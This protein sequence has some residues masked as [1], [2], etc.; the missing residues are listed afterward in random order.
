MI[1]SENASRENKLSICFV[2]ETYLPEVNGVARTLSNVITSLANASHTVSL[3]RPRQK[4]DAELNRDQYPCVTHLVMPIPLPWYKGI[5]GGMPAFWKL[6]SVWKSTRPDVIYIATEGPLGFAALIVATLLKI[7]VISGFHTNFPSYCQHYRV[8]F[9]EPLIYRYLRFFHNKTA[10]TL[11]P[12]R[13]VKAD[14][15]ARGF[16]RTEIFGRG[17]DLILFSPARRNTMLRESWGASEQDVVVLYVGR[18]AAEKNIQLALDAYAKT[19][20]VY[21]NLRF[22]LVGDGPVMSELEKQQEDLVFA[23][24]Q[25]GESLAAHYASADMFV[26]PS[27]TET[28]GNVIIEAMASGLPVVAY[29][30]AAGREFGSN[31]V[32]G[33]FVSFDDEADFIKA[34]ADLAHQSEVRERLGDQAR[35][36]MSAN[37]WPSVVALFESYMI[38]VVTGGRYERDQERCTVSTPD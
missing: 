36:N 23:G 27:K 26:F 10:L 33:C 24:V 14:L 15:D 25:H 34:Y 3:I 5:Q 8:G 30:Y 12:T 6:F 13:S 9:L 4:A 29:D 31:G 1:E 28:F 11:V 38:N 2:T 32:N 21:P 16:K 22:V 37:S 18:I 20:E 17:V 7:P 19:K 35:I